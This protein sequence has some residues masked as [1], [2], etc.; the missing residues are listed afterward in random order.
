MQNATIEYSSESVCVCVCL[1]VSVFL[2]DNSKSNQSRNMKLEHIV[3]YE[4]ISHKFEIG[5]CHTKVKVTAQLRNFSPLTT[6][7]TVRSHN[8]TLVQAG[9]LI[10]ISS[11]DTIHKIY[12]YRHA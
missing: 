10:L 8:S 4:N 7:Q 9:K 11:F 12:E 6:I 3:V 5:H 2:H 1:C